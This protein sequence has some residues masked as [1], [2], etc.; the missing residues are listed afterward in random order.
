MVAGSRMLLVSF[1]GSPWLSLKTIVE[2]LS[3]RGHEIV[4][5]VTEV[6]LLSKD[7][8]HCTTE[9]YPVPYD[10]EL[11]TFFQTFGVSSFS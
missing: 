7:S 6:N 11:K 3:Q 9:V 5:L 1:G 10:K 8:R 2:A 4:V